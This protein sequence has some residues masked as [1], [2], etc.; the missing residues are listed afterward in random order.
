MSDLEIMKKNLENLQNE[1][2]S[3]KNQ[4][5]IYKEKENSYQSS[6]SRIKKIQ[7]E[8]ESSYQQSINDCKAHEEEIK[9]KYYNY[10]KILENQNEQNEK[11]LTNEILLLKSEQKEKDKIIQ[12]LNE[13]INLL[14]EKLSKDEINYYVKEKEYEDIIISKERKL[15]ELNDAIKQIVEEAN[16]EGEMEDHE[17]EIITNALEFND[18]DVEDKKNRAE[19]ENIRLQNGSLSINEVRS[20]YG[21]EPV[22]WGNV[23]MNYSNYGVTPNI[24]NPTNIEPL[25]NN[26]EIDKAL[27]TVQAYKS[28]LYKSDLIQYEKW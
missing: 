27:K 12:S 18:L 15:S 7:S 16:E 23:P 1:N 9:K 4:I 5:Q 10:Q 22:P 20:G 21:E 13:K 17:A 3:L 11:R 19:I 24:L 6:I 14:N 8:Y 2:T 26:T 28:Q 25:G